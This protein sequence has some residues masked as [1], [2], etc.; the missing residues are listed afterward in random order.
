MVSC[1]LVLSIIWLIDFHL[2]LLDALSDTCCEM[3]NTLFYILP[4]IDAWV[5]F[6]TQEKTKTVS[7]ATEIGAAIQDF[8]YA[9]MS[10]DRKAGLFQD[11]VLGDFVCTE[12]HP[13]LELFDKL[14][15]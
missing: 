6:P 12:M 14:L 5:G 7:S 10:Y 11:S 1:S 4:K 3:V 13:D 15:H 2:E 8:C 9:L